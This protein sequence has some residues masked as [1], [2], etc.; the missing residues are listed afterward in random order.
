MLGEKIRNMLESG[1]GACENLVGRFKRRGKDYDIEFDCPEGWKTILKTEHCI[2]GLKNKDK[3]ISTVDLSFNPSMEQEQKRM[4]EMAKTDVT[5]NFRLLDMAKSYP[6]LFELLWYT[7]LPC[8]DVKG[9]TSQENQEYSLIKS[10]SWKGFRIPCSQIF[11]TS[12]TDQG[13][14]CTFNLDVAEDM[15]QK[16]QFNQ[17]ITKLQVSDKN[18]TFDNL[19]SMPSFWDEGGEPNTQPGKNK[20]LT[21]VLDAHSNKIAG[22]SV[23][24]DIDGFFVTVGSS[25]E[26]PITKLH[27]S[28]IRP[29]HNNFVAIKATVVKSSDDIRQYSQTTRNCIFEDE[30]DM[31]IHKI[32]SQKNCI[33]EKSLEYARRRMAL[34]NPCTPWYFPREEGMG[35]N[36]YQTRICDPYEQYEFLGLMENVPPQAFKSCLPDCNSVQYSVSI[37]AA[38]L[39]KCNYKNLGMSPL[40]RFNVNV[41]EEIHPAIWSASVVNQVMHEQGEVPWYLEERNINSSRTNMR[42]YVANGSDSDSAVFTQMVLEK[43][44]A[45]EK[46]I[47]MVTFFFE[48]TTAFEYYRFQKMTWTDFISQVGGI[49]GL[50]MGLSLVSFFEIIY[51]FTL[52]LFKNMMI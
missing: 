31:A 17:M 48:S 13:M 35:K 33:L 52:R 10:C 22:S 5:E 12:P 46:D 2:K 1:Y 19:K 25:N 34:T 6:N 8:F 28:L 24:E 37:T 7:Q 40:C 27:S 30:N 43:Y 14:C 50:C 26:Y 20:G 44:D 36:R 41:G 45:Y 3:Q 18:S 47:G 29:G 49:L 38:P 4:F 42:Y 39:R 9:V 15:F 51:W 11:K 16:G 32:Y 23:T 21:L